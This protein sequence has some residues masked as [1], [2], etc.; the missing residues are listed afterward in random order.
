M[1]NKFIRRSV[2]AV[3]VFLILFLLLLQR[4]E[5]VRQSCNTS[6]PEDI[7]FT[8]DQLFIQNLGVGWNLANT[9]DSHD[10]YEPS[11]NPWDYETYWGNPVT[12]PGMIEAVKSAGFNT[13]RI[14]VTWYEH[15]DADFKIDEDWLGRVQQVVDYV[16][17]SGLYVILNTHHEN[18]YMPTY[19][20]LSEAE[21]KL[22]SVWGQIAL[23]FQHYD[24]H[25]LFESMNEPRL[26]GTKDEWSSGTAES[27][28]VV[29]KLN[30]AFVDVV[31]SSPGRNSE[32][33]L[34]LPTYA[35]NIEKGAMEGFTMPE[36]SNRLIVSLHL[37]KPYSFA[38]DE[39]GTSDWDQ[40]NPGDTYEIDQALDNAEHI[41]VRNG[42]PVV[43]SEFGNFDKGNTH[44]RAQWTQYIISRACR[45]GIPC[46]WWDNSIF[47]R[48]ALAWNYPE[49][50][51]ALMS[52]N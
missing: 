31:R 49:I 13:I 19:D 17:D 12:T 2:L 11:P 26:V 34:L 50:V 23:R 1:K 22:R 40:N 44:A 4:I 33:Y 35:A 6:E 9:L 48:G 14:P 7:T 36:Q 45:L 43:I 28:A 52:C 25:L 51:D 24:E 38:L 5:V 3:I 16:Y 32:R 41:F 8:E 15:I 27:Q 29:N 10:R 47:D 20:N 21:A 46:V 18:W 39:H 30:A 42:V 37:Y